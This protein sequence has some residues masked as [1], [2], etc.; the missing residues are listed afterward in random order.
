VP[1]SRTAAAPASLLRDPAVVRLVVV[2]FLAF[3][4]FCLTLASLPTWAARGGATAAT[5]GTPTAVL[6]AATIL[7]QP[8]VPLL[9]RRTGTRTLLAAGLVA[10]GA[11]TPLYL[12]GDGLGWLV[13]V[14]AVRGVGFAILTVV[15]ATLT[16]RIAPPGRLG[17]VIG[18][19]GLGLAVPNVAAVPAGAALVLAGRFDVVAW[20]A[21]SPLLALPLL[22]PLGR[23]GAVEPRDRPRG[24]AFTAVRAAGPPSAVLIVVT[25]A[26]GSLVTYLPIA[27]PHGSLVPVA[28]FVFGAASATCRWGAGLLADR[29]GTRLLLPASLAAG[30]AGMAGVAAGL[31]AG[32]T[33]TYVLVLAGVMCFGLGYGAAQNLT[34]IVAFGRAGRAG[35]GA[36]SAVWNTAFDAGT[37]IGAYAT[38]AA[39]SVTGGFAWTYAGCA[40]L[41]AL[42]LPV[43]VASARRR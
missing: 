18:A 1:H 22:G 31:A 16:A 7:V 37:G 43:A 25:V 15:G 41:I 19:Y 12:V 5:A 33:G 13:A 4:S 42:L 21:V 3:S 32:G 23:A 6:L 10:L 28:L 24:R 26:G 34:L 38:G 39:A 20:L 40:V 35:T 14:S 36:A 30:A 9:E 11:V 2:A 8:L 29:V 27:R 17:A